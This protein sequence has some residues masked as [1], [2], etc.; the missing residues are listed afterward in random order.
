MA[1]TLDFTQIAPVVNSIVSQATGRSDLASYDAGQLISVAQTELRI[2]ADP[3]MKAISQVLSKTIF[4][5]RPYYAKFKGIEMDAI[6]YGNMTRKLQ[7]GD[8]DFTD[9]LGYIPEE[10]ADGKSIDMY[11]INKPVVLQTN[12]YGQDVFSKDLTT[13]K[14]QL[15]V[16][17]S[18]EN[19]ITQYISMCTQNVVD[20]LTQARESV[21]RTCIGNFIGGI[22]ADV[23]ADANRAPERVVHLLSEYN[24]QTGLTL[25][26]ES[27]YQPAN[28]KPFIQWAYARIAAISSMLTERTELFHDTVGDVKLARHTPYENQ[29]VYLYAPARFQMDMM[30]IADTY[31]DSYL[32]LA[33][34]ETVNYWQSA[35]TPDSIK[36]TPTY[37]GTDGKLIKA[38]ETTVENIFGVIFD[39]EALGYNIISS[40][41]YVTPFN[42]KGEYWNTTYRERYRFFNDFTENGVVLLLD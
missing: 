20:M 10:M 16:A 5:I 17:F 25:T 22:V 38:G 4:S 29:K 13:F 23:K 37:M 11:K 32:S 14:N 9:A 27:V 35:N 19:E 41:A 18:N 3:I 31:H 42:T 28:F 15:E 34:T 36:V 26:A 24:A 8:K 33:D 30:A 6:R 40:D 2:D 21:A 7:I 39:D 12:F 1:N